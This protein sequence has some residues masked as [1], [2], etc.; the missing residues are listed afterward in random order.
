MLTQDFFDLVLPSEGLRV[1][2]T[3]QN[4]VFRHFFGESN[5]WLAQAVARV[6][7]HQDVY[8]ACAS[9]VD[10]SGRTGT[11]VAKVRSFWMDMDVG[12]NKP[13]AKASEAA[14]ALLDF[15]EVLDL[16][17]PY[18]VSSG[19]GVHAYWPL[20]ADIDAADWRDT[21]GLLKQ[22][23]K[24]HGLGQD[25]SRTADVASILRPVGTNNHKKG[26]RKPVRMVL[27]GDVS[28]RSYIH[29][30]LIDALDANDP[31]ILGD[32]PSYVTAASND[33]LVAGTLEERE[34]FAEP[35]AEG[36]AVVRELR[37]KQGNVDN[38]LWH[39]AI[40]VIAFCEDGAEKAHAWSSGYPGYTKGET[41][42]KLAQV[43]Q[44]K[45]ISCAKLGE[46]L[47]GACQACPHFGKIKSPIVLGMVKG[48]PEALPIVTNLSV[49]GEEDPAER[50][51]IVLPEGF[52]WS[53]SH[54]GL[55]LCARAGSDD[56]G[57]ELWAPFCKT[58]F[59]PISR[60][61]MDGSFNMELEMVVRGSERRRFVVPNSVI[62][63]G[64]D[65]LAGLLGEHEIVALPNPKARGF[66]DAYL[67]SW[68]TR[69]K[70]TADQQTS[71]RAFGWAGRD[72]VV[73]DRV[74][75]AVGDKRP[76]LTEMAQS[77]APHV[78]AKGDLNTWVE[79]IDKAYNYDGQE[80]YQFIV[81]CGF[82]AI[83]LPLLKQVNGVTVYAHSEGT[84]YGKTTA[85]RAALSAWGNWDE[86]QLAD[87][88]VTTNYLWAA[89]GSMRHL[90]ILFDELTNQRNDVASD[91]VFSV[92]SGRA[93]RRLRADGTPQQTNGNW[94][95][96]MLAS[97]NNLLS[98]KLGQHRGN[99]EAEMSRLFEFT[100][101]QVTRLT[102]N[103]ANELFPKLLD[104]YGTAGPVFAEYVVKNYDA[105]V[106]MLNKVQQ[107]LNV[108]AQ[109]QQS[110][111][112][113]SALLAC[114]LVAVSICRKLG[115]LRFQTA[116]LKVWMLER[117]DENR[118][119]RTEAAV[120]PL[121]LFGKMLAD[122]WQGI[123]VT[124]GEG[125]VRR[126]ILASVVPGTAPRGQLVGR[127]IVPVDATTRPILMLNAASIKEWCNKQ[128]VSAREMF[129]ATVAAG[130]V[131][132]QFVKYTLGKGT[133]EYGSVSSHVRCWQVDPVR[134]GS[135]SFV[136]MVSDKL[137]VIQGGTAGAAGGGTT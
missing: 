63:K 114:V 16:P 117:L 78:A 103:E 112:Y 82:A 97:G 23:A 95:T 48:E 13:Y 85:Q 111:R 110:E 72:F 67:Q 2:G 90:P 26:Q 38:P 79:I 18:I 116:P 87:N 128:G 44:F 33:D 50:Q 80:Q 29:A 124:N 118:Q 35:I 121:E 127:A 25:T 83:L 58:Q 55:A 68:I 131:S 101:S 94:C 119:Q 20:D 32:T 107:G 75:T 6:D 15:C 81:A 100:M 77:L 126:N 129:N 71:H 130:W 47:P 102:P 106:D 133:V 125:D 5:A 61:N 134:V 84:A 60:L 21:A 14:K 108:A 123:L 37:D 51:E 7:A 92:G 4:G 69:L 93:K 28:S 91:L 43:K 11:N 17:R 22:A 74:I 104:N 24:D 46:T 10:R 120:D 62:A 65:G 136:G 89:M 31:D 96:I 59:Y 1:C 109:I 42:R 73:G 9:Y 39:N 19:Y 113:W 105:V 3:K 99:A 57:N 34:F 122:L 12:E 36:C 56:D 53:T 27:E 135:S 49:F 70:E 54:E 8:F 30:K 64:K 86:L 66:M 132:S 98:E 115:L 45:P 52:R 76:L 40:G 137:T 41:D 88:K